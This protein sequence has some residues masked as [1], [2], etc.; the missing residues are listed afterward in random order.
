MLDKQ[1]VLPFK[2]I[3]VTECDCECPEPTNGIALLS[4]EC[5]DHNWNPYPHPEC[6]AF[7]HCN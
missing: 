1:L 6:L 3:C 7:E 5:P 2:C 4:N